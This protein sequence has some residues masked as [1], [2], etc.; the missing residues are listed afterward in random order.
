MAPLVDGLSQ[1]AHDRYVRFTWIFG[2]AALLF[3]ALVA[4][5]S[6]GWGRVVN[7]GVA[8]ALS[9]AG[10]AYLF[11]R[12]AGL[13]E[14]VSGAVLP[15]SVRTEGVFAYLRGLLA[16]VG[17]TTPRSAFD[18]LVRNHL[19]VLAVGA[20]LVALTLVIRLLGAMRPRRR[21]LL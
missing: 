21:S 17:A 4:G 5:F 20:G 2:V 11:T 8:I 19:I 16:Y 14:R 12:I 9:A 3:A 18:L 15:A 6:G 10:G 13:H 1:G 7:I